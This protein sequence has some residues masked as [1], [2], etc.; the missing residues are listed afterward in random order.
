MEVIANTRAFWTRAFPT[1][2]LILLFA[3]TGRAQ[4]PT[5]TIDLN[6][7]IPGA[8][9]SRVTAVGANGN[10]AGTWQD[11]S[12]KTSAF[13]WTAQTGVRI[14]PLTAGHTAVAVSRVSA[15]GE[16]VGTSFDGYYRTFSW[17]PWHGLVWPYNGFV[18]ANGVAVGSTYPLESMNVTSNYSQFYMP[19][20]LDPRGPTA[21]AYNW[22]GVGLPIQTIWNPVGPNSFEIGLYPQFAMSINDSGQV[23]GY[24]QSQARQERPFL[25]TEAG[26]TVDMGLPAGATAARALHINAGGQ[27]FGRATVNGSYQ[28]FIWTAAGGYTLLGTGG[29]FRGQSAAGL[30]VFSGYQRSAGDLAAAT[31][32]KPGEGLIDLNAGLDPRGVNSQGIVVGVTLSG[33]SQQPAAWANGGIAVLNP[34][35]SNGGEV[36]AINE[37]N[38]AGGWADVGG[39]DHAYVWSFTLAPPVITLTIPDWITAWSSAGT[40]LVFTAT[41]NRGDPACA[42]D[43]Q[44]F[45]S[46]Q[47]L[48]LG[49]HT[50]ACTITDPI[51]QLT[52][53]ETRVVQVLAPGAGVAG[54]PGPAGPTGADGPTGPAGAQGPAGPQGIAGPQGVAGPQGDAG[55]AGPAGPQGPIGLQGP[56]G[57]TGPA[58]PAGATGP[59]GEGIPA[60]GMLMLPAGSPRPANYTFVGTFTLSAGQKKNDLSVDVYRRN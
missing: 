45:A 5:S 38:L 40:A 3:T 23:V 58:G 53:T 44:P 31:L 60:G 24:G 59:Q 12:G 20:A 6:S 54:Q 4:P 57:P 55:P 17:A 7:L 11:A 13:L 56:S 2:A 49:A 42:A 25:W 29:A 1:V 47:M 8:V 30:A 48:G 50:V 34:P 46:G 22:A 43:G 10:V 9:S 27:V 16:V 51:S 15:S 52:T 39:Q 26:G 14:V 19:S 41:S 36:L 18:N 21:I 33:S 28:A 35:G 37:E 32:Y